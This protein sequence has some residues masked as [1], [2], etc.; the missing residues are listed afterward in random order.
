MSSKRVPRADLI[1]ER[2]AYLEKINAGTLGTLELATTLGEFGASLTCIA[3]PEAILAQVDE[4]A[5]SLAPFAGTCFHLFDEGTGDLLPALCNPR[6]SAEAMRSRLEALVEDRTVAMALRTRKPVFVQSGQGELLLQALSTP[7]RCRGLF[8]GELDGGRK[9]IPDT[10]LSILTIVMRSSAFVLESFELYRMVRQVNSEL[11]EKIRRLAA[12]ERELAESRSLLKLILEHI[13]QFV[14]WKDPQGTYIGCNTN[15][16]RAA[17]CAVPAEV[18][19]RTDPDMPWTTEEAART[20]ETDREVIETGRQAAHLIEPQH[21]A[22]GREA[23][24]EANKVPLRDASGQIIGL[25]GTY[26]DI[27][28]RKA[29]EEK[30]SRLALTDTLTGL[31]NR[32]LF[33]ERLERALERG[34]RRPGYR[35]AVLMVD[36]DRFKGINDR[37]GHPTGDRLLIEMGERISGCL[38]SVDTVA[39][40]GGDEFAVL[41]E[42]LTQAGEVLQIAR[43]IAAAVEMPFLREAKEI[44]TSASIGVLLRTGGYDN[45]DDILRDVDIA[46]YWVKERGGRRFRVFNPGMHEA[47]VRFATLESDMRQA[48]LQ[49]EFSLLY[50]PVYALDSGHIRGLEALVRWRHEDRGLLRPK[51]FIPVAEES[52]FILDLG[53]WVLD[54]ACRE[55]AGWSAEG[56]RAWVSVNLSARQL[57]QPELG[58]LIRD[59]L[60][61]TGCP[62]ERLHLELTESV[63]MEKP[64]TALK[65]IRKLK[66]MGVSVAI[67]DFGTGYSSLSYLQRFPVDTL[68]IDKSFIRALTI[69]HGGMEIVRAITVLAHSLGLT[70]VAEGVETGEQLRALHLLSCE[71]VQGFYLSGPLP[72]SEARLL[73]K[74]G[75]AAGFPLSRGVVED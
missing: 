24:I 55:A 14:Y 53:R 13:P 66:D 22:D 69:S 43:R 34:K 29:N 62:A 47:A 28:E 23:W 36:L 54:Q 18:V 19:G 10:S 49:E 68:K 15:F 8:L 45:P 12:S 75:L 9:D 72:L 50:Q 33:M 64:E 46:M 40:L 31:P 44:F 41:L 57:V 17:G 56:L 1:K 60:G 63:L 16:A 73:L 30:L 67:D 20:S 11:E 26:Q 2:L 25:L 38:R 39:R 71:L 21:Q 48:L 59:V 6:E 65:T 58:D 35:F 74:G 5:R 37:F 61:R 70:V 52:G 51:E 32:A 42:E 4:R 27:T 7:Q 3:G